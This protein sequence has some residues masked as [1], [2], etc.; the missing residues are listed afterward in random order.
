M[1]ELDL[2]LEISR[3]SDVPTPGANGTPKHPKGRDLSKCFREAIFGGSFGNRSQ[4]S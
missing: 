4:V 2:V 1:A 3:R